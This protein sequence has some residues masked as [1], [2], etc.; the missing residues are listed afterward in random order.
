MQKIFLD[1]TQLGG[2]SFQL[3]FMNT[4]NLQ[5]EYFMTIVWEPHPQII[6]TVENILDSERYKE[7]GNVMDMIRLIGEVSKQKLSKQLE[8][9]GYVKNPLAK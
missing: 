5:T 9:M 3:G 7:I 6:I 1:F 4:K 8:N 2:N